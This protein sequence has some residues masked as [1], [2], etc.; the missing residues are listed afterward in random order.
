MLSIQAC[1]RCW[2]YDNE[3]DIPEACPQGAHGHNGEGSPRTQQA[4]SVMLW[5][6]EVMK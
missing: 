3:Q 4:I 6:L 1:V 2:E 5:V